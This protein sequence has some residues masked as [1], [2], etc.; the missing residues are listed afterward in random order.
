MQFTKHL[1]EPIKRGAVTTSIRVWIKPRVKVGGRYTL[2]E[3]Y[4]V[5]DKIR[6]ID[7]DEITEKIAKESGFN[8]VDDLVKTAKHGRGENVYLINFHYLDEDVDEDD[9]AEDRAN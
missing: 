6:L 3:G 4:V 5:V 1:R 9:Y 7:W 2:E 8:D